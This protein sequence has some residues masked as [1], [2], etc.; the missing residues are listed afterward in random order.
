MMFGLKTDRPLSQMPVNLRVCWHFKQGCDTIAAKMEVVFMKKLANILSISRIVGAA[1]LLLGSF[2]I[3]PIPP[4]S[5]SFFVIYILCIITDLADGPIARKTQSASSFGSALDSVAD[6]ALILSVLAI[7]IPILDFEMWMYACIA[8][9]L[10]MRILSVLIGLKKFRAITL[11]HTYSSKTSALIL[12]LFPVF[13]GLFGISIAFGIAAV[14][15]IV[16]ACEELFIVIRGAELDRD[17]TSMFHMK[18]EL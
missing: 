5:F 6:V 13:Y 15:A 8:L 18:R 14:L 2:A 7:L 17:I 10:G 9:V 11:L 4:L 1:V 12:A 16:A 3:L